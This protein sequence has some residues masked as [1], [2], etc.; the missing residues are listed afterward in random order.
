MPYK[1]YL[2]F[3]KFASFSNN[4][5]S[6]SLKRVELFLEIQIISIVHTEMFLIVRFA[7]PWL[8]FDA[9]KPKVNKF[10]D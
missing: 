10:I 1:V 5:S 3:K 4:F 9:N 6:F 8:R 2:Y 7:N